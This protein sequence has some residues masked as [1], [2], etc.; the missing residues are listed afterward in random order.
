VGH[1]HQSFMV[2]EGS[3]PPRMEGLWTVRPVYREGR[4]IRP[5]R[6]DFFS[7]FL[8]PVLSQAKPDLY[9]FP[10]NGLPDNPTPWRTRDL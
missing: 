8:A 7:G 9:L 3:D 5:P 2:A 4:R 10:G 6:M 1:G